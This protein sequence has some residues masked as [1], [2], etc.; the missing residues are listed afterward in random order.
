MDP[1]TQELQLRRAG[2]PRDRIYRDVGVSG[3]T[4]TNQRRGWHSLDARIAGGDTLV[5]AAI[6]RI[7][8]TWTDTI[9]AIVALQER[10]V[11]VKSLAESEAQW[12]KYLEAE[13]GSAEAFIGQILI[14]FGGVGSRPGTG[15]YPPAQHR[16]A[17]PRQGQGT[18]DRQAAGA[19]PRPGRGSPPA[20]GRGD[21]VPRAGRRNGGVRVD[22]EARSERSQIASELF[23]LSV[24]VLEPNL[25]NGPSAR[26]SE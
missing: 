21:D 4:G 20:E 10:G 14:M 18:A 24:V 7:G 8:R 12:T 25:A 26:R 6:D 1:A 2:V 9:R 19:D 15:V 3:A 23:G 5:V 22:A 16:G 17:E 13:A 11:K